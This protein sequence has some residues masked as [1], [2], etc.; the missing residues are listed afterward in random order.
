MMFKSRTLVR[1]VTAA[2]AK[3]AVKTQSPLLR[4]ML[5]NPTKQL[6]FAPIRFMSAKDNFYLD[7]EKALL[8]RIEEDDITLRYDSEEQLIEGTD[9][10]PFSQ[11]L[12]PNF[13]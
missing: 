1:V 8:E 12:L 13:I 6:T 7:L 10:E 9:F 11:W 2:A 4:W 5:F 3:S